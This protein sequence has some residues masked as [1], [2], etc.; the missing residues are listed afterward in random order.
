MNVKL[1]K[2]LIK[3]AVAEAIYEDL[4]DIL[5]EALKK[6]NRAKSLTEGT[7]SFTS[8]NVSSITGDVRKNL[9]E[10]MGN[11][12]GYNTPS[13]VPLEVIRD[14]VDDNTGEPV[15]P[16][17]AFLVDSANTMTPQEKAGFKNLG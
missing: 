1:F 8:N 12:M 14:Q 7:V 11:A 2:K 16:Y 15:N 13:T 3:E 9:V 5:S 6:H 10:K 17:L 4:P